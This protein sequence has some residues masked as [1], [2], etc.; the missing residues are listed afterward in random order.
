MVVP[1]MDM[2]CNDVLILLYAYENQTSNPI[3]I[4][5][6]AGVLIIISQIESNS[7]PTLPTSCFRNFSSWVVQ[8]KEM[9]KI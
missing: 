8:L 6:K 5:F 9:I 3:P 2:Y 7:F 1:Y 4:F